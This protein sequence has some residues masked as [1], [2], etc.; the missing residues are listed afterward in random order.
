MPRQARTKS[1]TN[2]YHIMLRGINRQKIFL[3]DSDRRHFIKYMKEVK[4]DSPFILHAYCL[5]DNH[6]HLLLK[7]T[8]TPIEIIMKRIGVKYAI[9][10]NIKHSRT[11]HVF[12]DRFRS[13][14]VEDDRYFLTV[15]R[16]IL[17]NPVK[18]GIC[19][20]PGDY[21]WSSYMEFFQPNSWV[22]NEQVISLIGK[23]ELI[24]FICMK[25]EDLCMDIDEIKKMSAWDAQELIQDKCKGIIF[26]NLSCTEQNELICSLIDCG[27]TGPQIRDGLHITDH[28]VRTARK[29]RQ[30]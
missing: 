18:A 10:F 14:A 3:D 13:E 28:R 29:S 6:V 17:Q 11:G 25:N 5:M 19:P 20:D 8:E 1:S 2:I 24:S 30:K 4:T 12:Q 27:C 16:Y 26:E 22:D 9:Y 23:K 15:L 7:E 21:R